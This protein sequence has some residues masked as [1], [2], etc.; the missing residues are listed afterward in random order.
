M[1]EDQILTQEPENENE[2]LKQWNEKYQLKEGEVRTPEVLPP[3]GS[4]PAA[5]GSEIGNSTVDLSIPENQAKMKE[6]YNEWWHLGKKRGLLG[7]P[8]NSPEFKGERDKLKE[9]WYNKYHSMGLAEYET[10]R[11][12]QPKKTMYGYD[13]NLKGFADQLD[14]NFKALSIPGLAW[15]DFAMDAAGTVIP[16]M[17]KVDDR[18]DEATQLDNPLYQNTRR[19]L[20]IVLPAIQTGKMTHGAL[21]ASP[22]AR[23]P[24]LLKNLTHIG[25][26]GLAD[27]AVTLLSD[28][29]EDHNAAKTV[30]D[31][32]PGWF[33]SKGRIP[34]PEAWK[35]KESDSPEARKMKNFYE[36]TVLSTVGVILGAFIDSK[37][38]VKNA[39]DFIEPLDDASSNYKQLELLKLSESEDII[40][41]QRLNT[42]L[43]S[44]KLSKQNENMLINEILNLE[45]RLGMDTGLESRLKR[46]EL[47][48]K[49]EQD[50]AARRKLQ[51]VNQLELD[52]PDLDPDITPGLL[53]PASSAR[54]VPPP[55][56]VA[57]NMA[58]TT[59][60][61][62]G[63]ST[64]DPAPIIT[65]SMREKGLMV[66]PTS[67]GAVM[68]VAEETRD[69]GRFNAIVDGVRYSAKQ[70]NA[71]AWDI[72]T[73]IIAAE[74]L[75][76]VKALFYE[77]RDVKNFLMG[78]FRVE[79]MNE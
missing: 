78:R 16:G 71:A 13:A 30:A 68:G 9:K 7:I 15:A 43:S 50:A 6:E 52:I 31:M 32:F 25:A 22:V 12:A 33:G 48:F 65:E 76:D 14:N 24:S 63:T 27:G 42:L 17:D 60:I 57:R 59:A 3:Q 58:D 1:E 55:A 46:Q 36:N 44:G 20:S 41:L 49:L 77:N 75:D 23:Y 37:S 66:G 34:L 4:F 54:Q 21:A 10:A 5:F 39:V 70:M 64:G 2:E 79:V 73:S 62:S 53:D 8:Y 29:S 19:V 11:Q 38:G 56:N 26:Y 72:Y 61:K 35:T 69:I 74:N 67:R 40:E 28:T 51:N 45:N 47:G 18:W